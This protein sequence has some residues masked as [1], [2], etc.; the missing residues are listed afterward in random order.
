MVIGRLRNRGYDFDDD[1]DD[2]DDD[3]FDDDDDDFFSSFQ[4]KPMP[5][6]STP[7]PRSQPSPEVLLADRL[8]REAPPDPS[9]GH[10]VGQEPHRPARP[11][12]GRLEKHNPLLHPILL[13]ERLF[14]RQMNPNRMRLQVP[15]RRSAVHAS[16][17]TCPSSKPGKPTIVM[18]LLNGWSVNSVRVSKSAPS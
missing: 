7:A 4:S 11:V 1:E 2:E 9:V 16:K 12:E 3:F 10:P 6:R 13:V 5:S 15:T 8:H 17:L 18:L 14:R